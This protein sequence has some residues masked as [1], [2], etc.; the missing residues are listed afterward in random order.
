MEEVDRIIIHSLR[1]IGCDV[2]DQVQSLRQFGTELIVAT[3][4]RCLKII[5]GDIDL[6][7]TL[8]PGMSARFR[9]GASLANQVQDLGYKGGDLGY[10]TFLYSNETE[11]RRIFMFLVEKLPK[12]TSQAADEPMGSSVLLRRAISIEIGTQLA[13]AWTPPFLKKKGIRSR[14]KPPG[15]QRE[16][17]CCLQHYHSCQITTPTSVGNLAVKIP[18]ELRAYYNK[19]MPYVTNQTPRHRDTAPSV[20]EANALEVAVQQDWENEWNQVGLASRLSQQEFKKRKQDRLLKLIRERLQQDSQRREKAGGLSGATG[21]LQQLL[22]SIESQAGAANVKTKGS[23]FANTEKLQYGKDEEKTMSQVGA[24][25]PTK[26]TEEELERK[27]QEE[28]DSLRSE[29]AQLTSDLEKLDLEVRKFTAS[30]QQMEETIGAEQR[31]AEQKRAAYS[32][33]KRTLD[34]LPDAEANIGK[35]Q[36]VVDTSA[37]RLVNLAKQWES[38]RGP[39][40]EQYR[41]LRQYNSKRESEAQ[42][43]LE[44]IKQFRARMKEVADDARRKDE[45]QK[46]LVSEYERMTKDVN[47]SAYTRKIME[48]VANIKKQKQEIDKILVDT[49]SVQKEINSLTGKL[50]RTFTV[51]D[52]LIFRDAKKDEAVKKAYRFLAAL[53]EN[54]E[55]LIKT[56]EDTG[57]VV[58]EIK[59][60]ED[61]IETESNK[62]V[63]QNLEKIT[64]DFQEMKKENTALMAKVKGKK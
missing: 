9:L 1:S 53:H 11:I 33:K 55:Q 46:Q 8:P 29:L 24:A 28:V 30:K 36:S 32:V 41:E 6:P 18:K 3:V 60:L 13:A 40:T 58:R 45:L 5:I 26:D 21:D 2:D 17:A 63:L 31:D 12:E 22:N 23:R 38:H 43:K 15:W 39:L 14:T 16:G 44:E 34:L 47:R 50:D 4:V 49:R 19:Q 7:S 59:D 10:Q 48:I 54:F 56:V 27:R 20:L 42:K 37:Q 64:A 35:L 57:A 25:V 51:T 62:K 52:E 61:Q